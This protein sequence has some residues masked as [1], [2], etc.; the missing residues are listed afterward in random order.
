MDDFSK[1]LWQPAPPAEDM[2]H[3]HLSR[4]RRHRGRLQGVR[5]R[6]SDSPA[7][8]GLREKG[9]GESPDQTY[10]KSGCGVY[11]GYVSDSYELVSAGALYRRSTG[12]RA[13]FT[14]Q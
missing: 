4:S 9:M 6:E 14:F 7:D 3:G 2:A 1:S 5:A 10:R 8:N 11:A 13:D 12:K